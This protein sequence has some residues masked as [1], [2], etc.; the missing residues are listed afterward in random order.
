MSQTETVA[1]TCVARRPCSK[2]VACWM[3]YTL[4]HFGA[5]VIDRNDV[6][7]QH[8]GAKTQDRTIAPHFGLDRLA[9]KDGRREPARNG[10]QPRRI[11]VALRFENG[12]TRDAECAEPVQNGSRE[13][14]R[15]GDGR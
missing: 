14:G 13:P 10:P 8:L 3:I 9:R 7:I 12:V 6:A 11:V 15:L 2:H 1:S 5:A 4:L